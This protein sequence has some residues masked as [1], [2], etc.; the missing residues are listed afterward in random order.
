MDVV[1]FLKFNHEISI[2]SALSHS[3]PQLESSNQHVCKALA[4]VASEL[5]KFHNNTMCCVRLTRLRGIVLSVSENTLTEVQHHSPCLPSL[6]A[7]TF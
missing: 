1:N 6:C 7:L 3:Y 4:C 2:M 5:G